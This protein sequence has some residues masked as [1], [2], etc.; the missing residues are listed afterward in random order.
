MRAW[1]RRRRERLAASRVLSWTGV[2]LLGTAAVLE[3]FRPTRLVSTYFLWAALPAF[4]TAGA[5]WVWE[6]R[7]WLFRL[8]AWG[9]RE[10]LAAAGV[11]LLW[12]GI[13]L[14]AFRPTRLV[15]T[16]FLWAALPAFLMAAAMWASER[17]RYRGRLGAAGGL[18]LVAGVV[19]VTFQSTKHVGTYSVW[20]G[21]GLLLA[22]WLMP[23]MISIIRM[24]P[25]TKVML[26]LGIAFLC[27]LPEVLV[28]LAT[29]GSGRLTLRAFEDL[30]GIDSQ[31]WSSWVEM[32][33]LYLVPGFLIGV[34]E[35][36]R[37]QVMSGAP[38]VPKAVDGEED[39]AARIKR[40]LP[41]WI[42]GCAAL[43]TGMYA[44]ILHFEGGPLAKLSL[45]QL[46]V[47]DVLAIAFLVPPYR[48]IA[49]A[50]WNQ[51]IA[52]VFDPGRW[53][54]EWRKTK[55]GVNDVFGT[56][57]AGDDEDQASAG[58]PQP[59]PGPQ[60]S[61][62]LTITPTPLSQALRAALDSP[63]PAVRVGAVNALAEWLTDPDPARTLTASQTLRH[64]AA[65]DSPAVAATARALIPADPHQATSP[66]APAP[67][68]PGPAP[69]AGPASPTTP[70]QTRTDPGSPGSQ[71]A[72]GPARLTR[73]L[74]GHF[75][76]AR[77][78]DVVQ[79][80]AFSPDGRLLATGDSK[81]RL[82]NPA[83]GEHIRTLT[84][85]TGWIRAVAFSPGGQLLATGGHDGTARL[86][87]PATGVHIRTLTGHTGG[88]WA[89]AFSPGGQLLATGGDDGAARLW[90]PATGE[91][92]RT[93]TGHTGL[94][95]AVAFSP[96]GHLLAT[97]GDDGAARLWNPATG[98][99]IR[100]LTGHTGGVWAV[101]FSPDGRLLA[102][103]SYDQTTRLWG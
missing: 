39:N 96:G 97:G 41:G 54:T 95:W 77:H 58:G 44:F 20:A 90:N 101:A 100:T 38:G 45:P 82:W 25:A 49:R 21:V 10:R 57:A 68:R 4:L 15:S 5:M 2:V 56:G 53:R 94:V 92:I 3:A 103:G 23:V 12:T 84:G 40:L 99:H 36:L 18:L 75:I 16:Y 35:I 59:D 46:A 80:V 48:L 47:A 32:T 79:A 1:K 29:G 52:E 64:I 31:G 22:A 66:G 50:I 27:A 67:H 61:V 6:R 81:A 93:L 55:S 26:V 42:A 78:N 70:A 71:T 87:N 69:A 89:V 98:E 19:M 51:G 88:V 33:L 9:W 72:L 24:S 76:W 86:W 43:A 63:L 91:H 30:T 34:P 102:T 8:G 85:H 60:G 7:G 62:G 73:T 13:V 65:T 14:E 74:K 11:L 37:H 83:T 28:S 17:W